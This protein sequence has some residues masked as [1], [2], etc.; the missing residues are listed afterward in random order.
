MHALEGIPIVMAD[1]V[2]P[3]PNGEPG[4][5][6][7]HSWQSVE[8]KRYFAALLRHVADLQAGKFKTDDTGMQTIDAILTN[9]MFLSWF[10]KNGVAL[11]LDIKFKEDFLC[12]SNL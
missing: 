2:K 8:P 12:T 10:Q 5:Y 1:A 6:K 7:E 3:G 4:R 9:A 11:D